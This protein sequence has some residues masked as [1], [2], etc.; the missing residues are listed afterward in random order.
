MLNRQLDVLGLE[1]KENVWVIQIGTHWYLDGVW[2]YELPKQRVK[3]EGGTN[4]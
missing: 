2:S 1:L 3:L 4:G